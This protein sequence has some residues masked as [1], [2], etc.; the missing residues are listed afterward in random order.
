MPNSN[1]LSRPK[2]VFHVEAGLT[3]KFE[4]G[5]GVS[6]LLWPFGD[7]FYDRKDIYT[8]LRFKC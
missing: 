7:L 5:L 3:S 1:V 4:M 8:F 2:A 6:P